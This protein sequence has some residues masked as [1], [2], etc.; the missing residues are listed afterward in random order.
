MADVLA[1][2]FKQLKEILILAKD[3]PISHLLCR[4]KARQARET[5]GLECFILTA[6]YFL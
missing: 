2:P 3:I 5:K 1:R 4:N 6:F